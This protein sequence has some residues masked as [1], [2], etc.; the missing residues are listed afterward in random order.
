VELHGDPPTPE[1]KGLID[2]C[3]TFYQVGGP[4]GNREGI[5]VPMERLEPLRQDAKRLRS[6]TIGGQVNFKPSYLSLF[7]RSYLGPQGVRQE[8]GAQA[9]P[10]DLPVCDAGVTN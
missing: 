1:G 8:L 5:S 9:D 4:L 3:V 10:E 2:A 7:V 6:L